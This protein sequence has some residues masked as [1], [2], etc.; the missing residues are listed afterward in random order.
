MPF[1]VRPARPERCC[2]D[3]CDTASIGRRCTFDRAL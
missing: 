3:A 1:E 2:A